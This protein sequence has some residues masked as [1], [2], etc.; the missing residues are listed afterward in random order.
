MR[1]DRADIVRCTDLVRTYRT[2]TGEVNALRGVSA[3]FPRGSV[4][5]VVGPSGSGKSS[6]LRLIAGMDRPSAGALEVDGRQVAD[7]SA[8]RRRR[9]R[10]ETVGYVFQR[11]SDNFLGHLTVGE[12][13]RLAAGRARSGTELGELLDALG[14]GHRAD[15]VASGLSGGEQQRAA[16]AQALA[17]GAPLVVAD[18]PTA[19]LDGVSGAVVLERIRVFAERGVSFVLATHDPAVVAASEHRL[20][21]EHGSVRGAHLDAEG[22]AADDTRSELAWPA[23]DEP[24]WADGDAIVR[25]S[26]I[27]KTYGHGADAIDA[28]IDIDLHA[29]EGEVVALV[30]RSGSGKTTLLNI[31]AGWEF[32]DR[33]DVAVMDDGAADW[34]QIA[35]LPQRLGLMD[36]LTVEENVGYPARVAG[37]LPERREFVQDLLRRFGLDRLQ[38]RY[39]RETSLGEQQRTALARMLVLR[40]RLLIADEPTGHQDAGWVDRIFGTLQEAV[41][42]GTCCIVATHDEGL[43]A[44]ADR[45]V[46]MSDGRITGRTEGAG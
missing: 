25:L 40:P 32:P 20:E 17:A 24:F 27:S 14:V 1:S 15:H 9:L 29:S 5:A 22:G 43:T 10:H 34:S 6:L 35:V 12:H 39:P 26:G 19:E 31:I 13:M 3:S 30:G 46:P 4:T 18:E 44:F 16:F 23:S 7:A 8:H 36:E 37:T 41:A 45:I 21:L 2:P 28:L 33:G 42:L 38:R 11:P